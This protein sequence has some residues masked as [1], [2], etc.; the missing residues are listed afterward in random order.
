MNLLGR[1]FYLAGRDQDAID[2]YQRNDD[3]GGPVGGIRHAVWAAAHGQLGQIEQ[4]RRHL[5]E[6][7]RDFPNQSIEKFGNLH[8]IQCDRE[9]RRLIEG[10]RKAGLTE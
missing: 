3:R 5:E 1:V 8:G 4:A 7:K 10:L 6:L 2:A 9:T